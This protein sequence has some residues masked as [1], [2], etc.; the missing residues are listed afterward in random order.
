MGG[1]GDGTVDL[2]EFKACLRNAN[3]G[4]GMNKAID[5]LFKKSDKDGSGS[6]DFDE[7]ASELNK[8]PE[9]TASNFFIGGG[10]QAKKK[11]A[12]VQKIGVKRLQ[13]M[14]L[15]KLEQ[16]AKGTA[17]GQWAMT[18][19][20]ILKKFFKEFDE[21]DSGELDLEEFTNAIR[22]K[23]GLMNVHEDDIKALFKLFDKRH[24]GYII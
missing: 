9:N 19:P 1:A 21:D 3:L 23:L 11:K 17:T 12:F 7:F 15:D 24:V 8:D 10:R 2:Y 20:H 5:M 4:H 13:S 6:I 14:L 22:W 18:S 16:K